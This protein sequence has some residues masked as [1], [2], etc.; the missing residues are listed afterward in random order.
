M[1]KKM[2]KALEKSI[3]KWEKNVKLAQTTPKLVDIRGTTCALCKA[4]T[5]RW[6]TECNRCPVWQRTGEM[7]CA[8]TPYPKVY[9]LKCAVVYSED[10]T[11]VPALIKAC[12]KEVAFLKSLRE[13]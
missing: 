5:L 13:L 3:E 10:L 12:K 11:K 4:A 7:A 8:R 6:H 1:T 9:A 2:A